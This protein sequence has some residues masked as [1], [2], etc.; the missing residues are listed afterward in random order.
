MWLSIHTLAESAIILFP[1]FLVSS[2][3]VVHPT[4]GFGAVHRQQLHIYAD[5]ATLALRNVEIF[6]VQLSALCLGAEGDSTPALTQPTGV[7]AV[8]FSL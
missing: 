1:L 4:A 5:R 7:H 3:L 6:T 2:K 8:H